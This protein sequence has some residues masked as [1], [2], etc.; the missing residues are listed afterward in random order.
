MCLQILPTNRGVGPRFALPRFPSNDLAR[1]LDIVV[2]ADL[3]P[4]PR[5][6]VRASSLVD[7]DHSRKNKAE[8][9]GDGVHLLS[10]LLV[11]WFV[12]RP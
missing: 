9:C 3:M 2:F 1:N 7:C 6:A 5:L 4:Q 8:A 11:S 12:L 10:S